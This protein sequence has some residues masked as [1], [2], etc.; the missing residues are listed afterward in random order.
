MLSKEEAFVLACQEKHVSPEELRGDRRW[1]GLSTA[2]HEIAF[3]MYHLFRISTIELGALMGRDHT[4][5]MH[6][7]RTAAPRWESDQEAANFPLLNELALHAHDY[8]VAARAKMLTRH[9]SL[10]DEGLVDALQHALSRASALM[11]RLESM[12]DRVEKL[13]KES[14]KC[15]DAMR[16]WAS[17]IS[18]NGRPA[19]HT[20]WTKQ[21][22]RAVIQ[23]KIQ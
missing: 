15:A 20:A 14:A 7:I 1:R 18:S 22:E 13:E 9:R 19:T 2:R 17:Q 23:R 4:T 10:N 11:G 8:D 5:V 16:W 6:S 3:S 12:V 21:F